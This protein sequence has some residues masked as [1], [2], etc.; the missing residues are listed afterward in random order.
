[1]KPLTIEQLKSLEVGDWVWVVEKENAYPNNYFH[2]EYC[3]ITPPYIDGLCYGWQGSGGFYK[4]CDYDTKW[5]AYKNKE[6]AETKGEIV[7]LPC[8]VGDYVYIIDNDRHW[9]KIDTIR[10]YDEHN[11]KQKIVYEWA[12]YDVG[13]DITELWDEGEFDSEEIGK[14]ILLEKEHDEKIKELIDAE[15]KK[16]EAW[17]QECERRRQELRGEK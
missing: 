9:A 3:R 4:Y 13:V 11:G 7:E 15:N 8:K 17:E 2:G 10:I 6:Q 16:F 14:T 12:Q 5:L 1:M